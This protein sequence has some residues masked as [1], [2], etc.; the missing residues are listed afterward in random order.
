[1]S[2]R[3][4]QTCRAAHVFRRPGSSDRSSPRPRPRCRFLLPRPR[5]LGRAE[6]EG[7]GTRK[8]GRR[9]S[10]RSTGTSGCCACGSTPGTRCGPTAT[11][12]RSSGGA[13]DRLDEVM[14]PK[15]RRAVGRGRSRPSADARSKR[16]VGLPAGHV[17]IEAQ[18]ETAEG[19]INVEEICAASPRLES[20]I[21][22]PADFAASIGMPVTTIDEASSRPRRP[23]QLRVREDPDGR[24]GQR[25]A[26]HRRALPQGPRHRGA[27]RL[28]CDQRV[29]RLRRQVGADPGSGARPERGLLADQELFDKSLDILDAYGWRPTSDHKGAVMFGDEM[30]DEARPRCANPSSRAACARAASARSQR[31]SARRSSSVAR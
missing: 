20:I 5:G 14:L 27:A 22:G 16:N 15:V 6:R 4:T 9:R 17:G 28:R 23:F 24:P 29:L 1:M 10:A 3:S 25:P 8:G 18:I 12:S 21:F 31:L 2:K 19:L 11:S 26:R 30:I 13:G 7:R